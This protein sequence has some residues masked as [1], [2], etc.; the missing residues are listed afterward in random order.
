MLLKIIATYD[1]SCFRCP[2]QRAAQ[3]SLRIGI[4]PD[5]TLAYIDILYDEES[6]HRRVKPLCP[7]GQVRLPASFKVAGLGTYFSPYYIDTNDLILQAVPQTD[8]PSSFIN[9][10]WI[11]FVINLNAIL[12]TIQ[13]NS[14]HLGVYKLIRFLS[15]EKHKIELGGLVVEFCTFPT[16]EQT[17][18]TELKHEKQ[19]ELTNN[20]QTTT[21]TT[22]EVPISSVQASTLSSGTNKIQI[23]NTA[24]SSTSTKIIENERNSERLDSF[25]FNTGARKSEEGGWFTNLLDVNVKNP[26][27][28]SKH[29]SGVRRPTSLREIELRESLGKTGFQPSDLSVT[30]QE[31]N[32]PVN[33][34]TIPIINNTTSSSNNT[35]TNSST[36][37]TTN[38]GFFQSI[39]YYF[40][41]NIVF[42]LSSGY[43]A[44]DPAGKT[45]N[46]HEMCNAIQEGSLSMGIIVTHPK[47]DQ[48]NYIIQ[49]DDY[50]SEDSE[51]YE[52]DEEDEMLL[53]N[54]SEVEFSSGSEYENISRAM[55]SDSEFE[56]SN[57]ALASSNSPSVDVVRTVSN[58]TDMSLSLQR[59]YGDKAE[60]MQKFYN[61]MLSA[62]AAQAAAAVKSSLSPVASPAATPTTT[63]K[64]KSMLSTTATVDDSSELS[65]PDEGAAVAGNK[66][67][68]VVQLLSFY[69]TV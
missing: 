54:N 5:S 35:S 15:D 45:L 7:I 10:S 21:I 26:W 56:C 18:D 16:V 66:G 57:P 13:F 44:T 52:D 65:I 29:P 62:E 55:S 40:Y 51:F 27:A 46:F 69:F 36:N 48:N 8:I 22:T 4:S 25:G 68:Y 34:T 39:L 42:Y 23:N 14:I 41:N 1:Y 2:K 33:T 59:V 37:T 30:D 64:R 67:I 3:N 20:T 38:I 63:S 9:D 53:V 31:M 12:R 19:R 49:D 43:K 32:L 28:T 60:E 61:I 58:A 17:Y 50:D 24:T 6:F 47:V 11:S